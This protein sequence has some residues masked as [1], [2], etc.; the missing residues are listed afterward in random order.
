LSRE[1]VEEGEGVTVAARVTGGLV[2]CCRGTLRVL[3]DATPATLGWRRRSAEQRV[4]TVRRGRLILGP[5]TAR[6]AD[7]FQLCVR[8]RGSEPR[9]LLVLPRVQPL[10][11]GDTAQLLALADAR[12]AGAPGL[13]LDGLRPAVP[14]AP[15]SRIHWLTAARTGTPMERRFCEE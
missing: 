15:A 5:A 13:E 14:G 3:G 4:R 1:R 12:A 6:W 8:D 11:A 9:E 10:R 7:P 2:G